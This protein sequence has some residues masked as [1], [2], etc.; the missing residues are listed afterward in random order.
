ML[1]RPR[2][3]AEVVQEIQAYV[4]RRTGRVPEVVYVESVRAPGT[5]QARGLARGED[6]GFHTIVVTRCA[7]DQ[8]PAWQGRPWPWPVPV[9]LWIV[10]RRYP[11]VLPDVPVHRPTDPRLWAD[12]VW[13]AVWGAR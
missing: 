6:A 3:E 2:T 4:Q 7:C 5:L 1:P 8:A 9:L 12:P 11:G 10:D 13:R